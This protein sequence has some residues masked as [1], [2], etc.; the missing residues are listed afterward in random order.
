MTDKA[1]ELI[2]QGYT[3]AEAESAA[4]KL[5]EKGLLWYDAGSVVKC[6]LIDNPDS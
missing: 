2:A 5:L 1:N 6:E 4:A 3:Q